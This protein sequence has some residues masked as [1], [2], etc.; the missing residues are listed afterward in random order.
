MPVDIDGRNHLP[1]R[2]S[3]KGLELKLFMKPVL[4][5]ISGWSGKSGCYRKMR[6]FYEEGGGWEWWG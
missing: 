5:L 1:N 4:A 3:Y 2:I 6:A